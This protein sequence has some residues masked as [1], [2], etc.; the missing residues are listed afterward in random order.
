MTETRAPSSRDAP[1]LD[2]HGE[3][4]SVRQLVLSVWRKR[5]LLVLLSRKEFHVRYRRAAFGVLWAVALPLLQAG[6][7]AIV[8]SKVVRLQIPHY[9]IFV[10]SG[11]IG[12]T[13]FSAA[14]STGSTAIVD[15]SDL[16][17][18]VYF[19]RAMLPMVASGT[20]L[21]GM[22][23]S[24]VILLP[25]CLIFGVHLGPRTLL[26]LPAML[27]VVTLTVALSLVLSAVHVYFRDVRYIVSAATLLLLYLSPVIYAPANAPHSLRIV[28]AINPL[29][30]VLDL[31][32]AATVGS[33]EALAPPL[34]IAAA[35]TIGLLLVG[36]FLQSRFDRVFADLL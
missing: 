13:F 31:F 12:W 14:F 11:M 24:T 4:T 21:Y 7:M 5:E 16:S 34:L 35:W 30:G 32:H 9:P 17:S 29:T 28:L 36:L 20:N 6:V 1:E 8:F 22:F 18:R 25:L 10:L 19:P 33:F 27:W 2:L 15:G 26:L 3:T 23:I